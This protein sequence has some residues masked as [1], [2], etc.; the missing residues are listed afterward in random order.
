MTKES[1]IKR[2]KKSKEQAMENAYKDGYEAGRQ[3]VDGFGD[4]DGDAEMEELDR[5]KDFHDHPGRDARYGWKEFFDSEYGSSA[6]STAERF[7]FLIHPEDD[8]DRG[9][10]E[11]FWRSILDDGCDVLVYDEWYRGFAEG[12]LKVLFDVE[13]A[14]ASAS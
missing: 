3:W 5:L 8:G 7:Y 10:A 4:K 6:Y 14:P 1:T 9:E 11:E 12:A 2:L 13:A